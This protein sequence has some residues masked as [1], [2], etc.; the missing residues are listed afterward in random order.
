MADQDGLT[1][2]VNRIGFERALTE[3]VVHAARYGDAGSV[4]ALGIDNFQYVNESLGV[5]AGDEMLVELSDLIRGRLRKT[6]ILG[7]VAGD[8]FGVLV[9]GADISTALELAEELL[10]IA[11]GARFVLKGE[12]MRITASAGVERSCSRRPR[13][14][15]IRRRTPAAIASSHTS[16]AAAAAMSGAPGPSACAK[17]PRGACSCW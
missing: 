7:R 5:E 11:R 10:E 2:T 1:E 4:I 14:R 8:V 3:H 9:H 13:R 6:D 16:P 17:R 15:C 12:A